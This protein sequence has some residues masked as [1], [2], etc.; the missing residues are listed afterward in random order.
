MIVIRRRLELLHTTTVI[1]FQGTARGTGNAVV[2]AII[3][4]K[5]TVTT[6]D[7]TLED[8][9]DIVSDQ[10]ALAHD[11][12]PILLQEGITKTKWQLIQ[13]TLVW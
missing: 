5:E 8:K 12:P 11:A 9:V 10:R 2:N 7:A 6:T 4:V 13:C 3:T 1:D